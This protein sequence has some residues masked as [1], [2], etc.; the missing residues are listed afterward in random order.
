LC[1]TKCLALI[2]PFL[3]N[4]TYGID[5][6]TSWSATGNQILEVKF[7]TWFQG[8]EVKFETW[9]QGGLNLWSSLQ[10]ST[11]ARNCSNYCGRV[12]RQESGK[13]INAIWLE[14][15]RRKSLGSFLDG[16]SASL[17]AR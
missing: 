4:P 12:G 6:V 15:Q 14:T 3:N 9:L 17:I 2:S 7:Q 13:P 11:T 8:R 5:L 16:S 1:I 10:H